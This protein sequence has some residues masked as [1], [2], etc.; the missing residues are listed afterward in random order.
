MKWSPPIWNSNKSKETKFDQENLVKFGTAF[1][2]PA[3]YFDTVQRTFVQNLI[4]IIYLFFKLS[5]TKKAWWT[6]SHFCPYCN[7][8]D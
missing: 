4:Q 6:Q 7:K 8:A 1:N 3:A 5:D 2:K